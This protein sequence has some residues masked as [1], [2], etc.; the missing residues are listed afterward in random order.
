[1]QIKEQKKQ[2]TNRQEMWYLLLQINEHGRI[3]ESELQSVRDHDYR[4][5]DYNGKIGS[6]VSFIGELVAPSDKHTHYRAWESYDLRRKGGEKLGRIVVEKHFV[7]LEDDRETDSWR[8]LIPSYPKPVKKV[9]DITDV[10]LIS[11]AFEKLTGQVDEK[12]YVVNHAV[13][14]GIT[15]TINHLKVFH[16]RNETVDAAIDRMYNAAVRSIAK[17]NAAIKKSKLTW[18]KIVE[19][20]NGRESITDY[21][22]MEK[23]PGTKF[24]PVGERE[25]GEKLSILDRSLFREV[26]RESAKQNKQNKPND[27]DRE[28]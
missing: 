5:R 20:S 6:D 25:E 16:G 4:W 22:A 27:N 28:M 10:T 15:G 24:D 2:M 1:M 9:V 3:E 8:N 11:P 12:Q 17:E 14:N 7:P 23:E 19:Q 26:M 21:E 18:K 13:N